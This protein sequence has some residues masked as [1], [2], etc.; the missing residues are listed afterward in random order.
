MIPQ[1]VGETLPDFCKQA[2]E[3]K[4]IEPLSLEKRCRYIDIQQQAEEKK[5]KQNK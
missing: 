4:Y 3:K 2:S 5:M 1:A